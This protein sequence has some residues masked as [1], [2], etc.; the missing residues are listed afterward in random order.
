MTKKTVACKDKFGKEHQIPKER[1]SFRIGVA[2]ILQNDT[3][4]FLIKHP[5][6]NKWEL[7]GGEVELGE[8]LEDALGR[9]YSEE[10][11]MV[12]KDFQ[13]LTYREDFYYIESQNA[14]YHSIRLFFTVNSAN[15]KIP[16]EGEFVDYRSMTQD[17]T[18]ELTYS[19]L[20]ELFKK[21][22]Y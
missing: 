18:N 14:A 12:I 10:P 22:K 13:F 1:L 5:R 6:T 15:S 19:V 11:G 17:N 2:G 3:S 4:I 20:K 9:E 16:T 7:P 21:K 8:S